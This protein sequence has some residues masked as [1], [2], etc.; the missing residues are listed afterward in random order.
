MFVMTKKE[1][2]CIM[3]QVSKLG[4]ELAWDDELVFID[5]NI[6]G[7]VI[8]LHSKGI[9][10]SC[11]CGHDGTVDLGAFEEDTTPAAI[12]TR[13]AMR[14]LKLGRGWWRVEDYAKDDPPGMNR[15]SAHVLQIIG[16]RPYTE[17]MYFRVKFISDKSMMC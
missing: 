7:L 5:E 3:R 1:Y 9:P 10:T 4:V 16:V 14:G 17:E 8:Y 6:E 2:E 13:K 11:S 15:K 12:A